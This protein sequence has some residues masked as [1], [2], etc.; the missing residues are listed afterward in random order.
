MND[1]T[2]SK[3]RSENEKQ[4]DVKTLEEYRDFCLFFSSEY[5]KGREKREERKKRTKRELPG[6][7]RR[8][9]GATGKKSRQEKDGI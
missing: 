4:L 9:A 6:R 7:P 8:D 3:G 1:W 2:R 5:A